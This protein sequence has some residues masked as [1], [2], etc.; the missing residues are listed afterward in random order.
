MLKYN[1]FTYGVT[2]TG[3]KGYELSNEF[4][5]W[6]LKC[7]K[8]AESIKFRGRETEFYISTLM[9]FNDKISLKLASQMANVVGGRYI[10]AK[11]K[12]KTTLQTSCKKGENHT[13]E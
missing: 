10:E 12:S 8:K 1:V 13:H 5:D 6:I 11:K 2:A 7:G 3:E 4:K 9:T